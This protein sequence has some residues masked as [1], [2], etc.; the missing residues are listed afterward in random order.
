MVA[1][2]HLTQHPHLPHLLLRQ[3]T[4][5]QERLQQGTRALAV[6]PHRLTLVQEEDRL[7]L[8]QVQIRFLQPIPG[9]RAEIRALPQTPALQVREM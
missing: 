8:T 6:R 1:R 7:L 9:L 2:P 4:R 5:A 3:E